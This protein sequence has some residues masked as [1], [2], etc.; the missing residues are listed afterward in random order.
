MRLVD[1]L[2]DVSRITR[3]K[4]EIRKQRV[5]LASVIHQS[6]EVCRPLAERARHELNVSLPPEAIYLHA[7]PVRMAQVFANLLTNACKYTEPGGRIGLTAVRQGRDVVVNV[8]DTGVGIPPDKL[9]SVFEDVH[10][11]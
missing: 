3:G 5:E 10:T 6:V 9:G 8:K 11:G 4:L 2:L 1:D 7:D